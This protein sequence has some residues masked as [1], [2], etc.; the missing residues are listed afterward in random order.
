MHG[1]GLARG[2]LAG[3]VA[4]DSHNLIIAGVSDMDMALAGNTLAKAGGGYCIVSGGKVLALLELPLAGLMSLKPLEV[5]VEEYEKLRAAF[6]SVALNPD[7]YTH[8]F[9]AM[10]FSSLPVIP[11][12]RLT[13]K[14]LVDGG[15]V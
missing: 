4:H 3:T 7:V 8:P 11:E 14:G 13:D 12:L 2:A 9:M 10:S 1:L 15:Q 5:V 6:R